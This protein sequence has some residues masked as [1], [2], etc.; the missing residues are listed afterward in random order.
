MFN[1]CNSFPFRVFSDALHREDITS[2]LICVRNSWQILLPDFMY[3]HVPIIAYMCLL[4]QNFQLANTS[5]MTGNN[6]QPGP[7]VLQPLNLRLSDSSRSIFKNLFSLPSK[8]TT[9]VRFTPQY[10]LDHSS[11]SPSYPRVQQ[12]IIIIII[13]YGR[14]TSR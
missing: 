9:S 13:I 2:W 4:N 6:A 3:D 11:S 8:W 7:S 14:C 5:F 10:S 12:I 1:H